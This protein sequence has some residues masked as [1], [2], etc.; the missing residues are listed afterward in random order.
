RVLFRSSSPFLVDST[1]PE[2]TNFSLQ[3]G[4]NR[5]IAFTVVDKTSL[6]SGVF[7]SYDG[8]LWFPVFPVDLIADSRSEN[9]SFTLKDMDA[10]KNKYVFIKVTDEF[11]NS[12]VFQKEL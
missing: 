11:D 10:G 7:Y 4:A 3:P 2:L 9:Y 1:A 12:K 8:E 6:V 5:R